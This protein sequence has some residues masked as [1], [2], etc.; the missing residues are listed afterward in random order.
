MQISDPCVR[1]LVLTSVYIYIYIYIHIQAYVYLL[2][3]IYYCVA[4]TCCDVIDI[5]G[6]VCICIYIL[7]VT[8][9]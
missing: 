1:P 8:K 7:Q 4:C 2:C 5:L 9:S 3:D 6:R